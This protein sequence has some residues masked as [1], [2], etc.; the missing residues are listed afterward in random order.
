MAKI[1]AGGFDVYSKTQAALQRLRESGVPEE[2]I[3]EF[4]VNPPGEHDQ[5]P[6]GG[7]RDESPGAKHVDEGAGKGVAVGAA[8]GTAAGVTATP[9]LGPAGIVAGAAVGGYTGALVG[10]MRETGQ[11]RQPDH[12]DVRPAEALVAVNVDAAGVADEQVVRI[13]EECGAQQVEMADGLWEDGEWKDFNPVSP[14]N[15]VGGRDY[16]ENHAGDRRM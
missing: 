13:F 12:E 2:F 9:F 1:I 7:D 11:E 8:I 5:T 16:R 4:R 14:P 6:I 3:C 10:G 15:L